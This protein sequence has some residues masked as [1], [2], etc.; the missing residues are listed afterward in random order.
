MCGDG[1]VGVDMGPYGPEPNIYLYFLPTS[2]LRA[3]F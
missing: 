3:G 2:E 1:G